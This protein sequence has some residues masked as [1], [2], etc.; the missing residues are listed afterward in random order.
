MTLGCTE[1][2][3][4]FATSI[5]I[6]AEISK[7]KEKNRK[8]RS[9]I[10]ERIASIQSKNPTSSNEQ[11]EKLAQ[12][13]KDKDDSVRYWVAM[14]IG[15]SGP[16]AKPVVPELIEALEERVDTIASKSSASGIVHTLDRIEPEWRSSA[17]VSDKVILRW[18]KN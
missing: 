8:D 13:L 5:S 18:P 14:A 7:L 17:G 12:F 15:K 11:I 16:V 2:K 10:A 1:P 6:N 3:K 4:A 9:E